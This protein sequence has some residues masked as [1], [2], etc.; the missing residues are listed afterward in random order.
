[1]LDGTEKMQCVH[2]VSGA[3][4][5]AAGVDYSRFIVLPCQRRLKAS[6]CAKSDFRELPQ[7][8]RHDRHIATQYARAQAGLC[9]VCGKVAEDLKTRP[10]GRQ[11][12]A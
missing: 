12:F 4:Q 10:G 8:V 2:Y 5:C 1:M 7:P 6:T 9:I 3:A 11:I